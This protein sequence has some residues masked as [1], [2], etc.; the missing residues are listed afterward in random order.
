MAGQSV[1]QKVVNWERKLAAN[2]VVRWEH[3]SVEWR[4]VRK[5]EKKAVK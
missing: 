2:L 1:E 5:A 3:Q 4:A